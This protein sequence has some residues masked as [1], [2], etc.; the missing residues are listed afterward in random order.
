MAVGDGSVWVANASDGTISR[1]DPVSGDGERH[2]RARRR[3]RDR[4][5]GRRRRR[6]GERRGRRP[7]GADRPRRDQVTATINVGSGPTA[8]AIGLWVG[9]GDQQP[10]RDGLADRPATSAVQATIEVGDGAGAIASG[11][12]RGLG[13]RPVRRHASHGST[14]RPTAWTRTFSVGSLPQ[15]LA[16][17]DGLVWVGGARRRHQPS[18]RDAD[19][20]GLGR[21]RHLGPGLYGR[22]SGPCCR[23]TNDGLTAYQH[24]GGSGSVQLVPD[25][26]AIAA[27]PDRRRHDVHV[28]AAARDPLLGRRAGQPG[29]LPPRTRA[30]PDP[31]SELQLRDVFA[32]VVGGAACAAHPS[33]CDLSRGVVTDDAAEHRDVSPRR[34]E[35][36]VPGAADPAGRVRRASRRAHPQHRVSPDA[37]HRPLQ[38]GRRLPG[39]S[40]TGSQPLLS[41][42]VARRAAGRLPGSNRPSARHQRSRRNDRDRAGQGRLQRRRRAR[43]N[44]STS[45][46]A[47]RQP[48]CTSSPPTA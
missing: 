18:R 15:G 44:A 36:R 25:L 23:L 17:A 3:R 12:R 22:T 31:G 29:G 4:R 45:G 2:D 34:A 11:R 19:G 6:V 10:G 16:V 28:P 37:R 43:G 13:R 48:A 27:L 1:I 47:V 41:R 38:V 21:G 9:V 40:D 42:V 26:A 46:N 39:Q 7:G 14:R 24:V 5:R 20:A 30:R 33:H 8:I 35:S 32:D